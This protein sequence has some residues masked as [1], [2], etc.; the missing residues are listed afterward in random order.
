MKFSY[1]KL[2]IIFVILSMA[3]KNSNGCQCG[4]IPN[5]FLTTVTAYANLFPPY[6][7]VKGYKFIDSLQGGIGCKYKV[8]QNLFGPATP[9]TITIW[10]D[11]GWTCMD[12]ARFQN[13]DTTLV[14]L[15]QFQSPD[16]SMPYV[17]A[18][19]YYSW[20]CGYST[21]LVK[22]DS[23]YGGNVNSF[24]FGGYPY[25]NFIDTLQQTINLLT[26][27]FSTNKILTPQFGLFPNPTIG[28]LFLETNYLT[29][30][31]ELTVRIID[32]FGQIVLQKSFSSNFRFQQ[33]D[34]NGLKEGVYNLC[35][36]DGRNK[37]YSQRVLFCN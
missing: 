35:I 21:M 30:S 8:I 11:P 3:F 10:G 24:T 5:D 32:I 17:Q 34:I 16:T 28:K 1:H 7:I 23:V 12:K 37:L 25:Y 15:F 18:L 31:K 36:M 22:G 13:G 14:L 9:D 27:F 33:L 26:G 19:D 29:K 20:F 6:S 4:A 2:I